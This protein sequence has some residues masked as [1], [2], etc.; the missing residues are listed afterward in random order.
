MNNLI[1]LI[2][3]LLSVK[4]GMVDKRHDINQGTIS[5]V[6]S[7]ITDSTALGLFGNDENF[8]YF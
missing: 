1:C 7:R 5:D 6:C 3:E 4:Y 8:T 2:I